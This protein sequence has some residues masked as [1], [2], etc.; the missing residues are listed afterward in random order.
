MNLN[1][2]QSL[3][4]GYGQLTPDQKSQVEAQV[5]AAL[6]RIE[7]EPKSMAWRLRDRVGDRVKW[8]KEVDEVH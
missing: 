5:Q 2:V 1:K 3:A 6:Q 8:Y 7:R 4:H